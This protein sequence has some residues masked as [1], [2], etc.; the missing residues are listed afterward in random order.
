MKTLHTVF[1][2]LFLCF[3][4]S[5]L[6]QA[7]DLGNNQVSH[8][9]IE[10][11]EAELASAKHEVVRLEAEL[12]KAKQQLAGAGK[13]VTH[14]EIDVAP[15]AMTRITSEEL[16]NH[17]IHDATRVA[18]QVPGMLFGQ[19][20]NEAR[21]AI[22]GAHTNRTGPESEQV[23]AIYE[24]GVPALTTTQAL[25]PYVD[26]REIEIL[27]GPQGVMYG[28]NALGGVIA[29]HS[30]DPDPSG[31]DAALQG[32]IAFSDFTR[33]EAMLN[34]P[35]LET[36]AIRLA[37]ASESVSGYVNNYVLE[38]DA[39]DLKTRVRQFLRL[40]ARWQPSDDFSLQL[41][42]ASLDQNGTGSGMWGYQ[43]VG[44]M[45]DGSYYPGHHFAPAGA[46]PDHGP[47][48]IARNMASSAELE[49]LGTTLVL[50]W[51]LGFADLEWL[52]NTSKFESMQIFDGDYSNGGNP[53]NSDFNGW[54]SFM[55][56]VSSDLRLKSARQGRL[57]WLVGA[58]ALSSESDWSWLEARD[59]VQLKPGWDADGLYTTES[60]AV[61]ASAGFRVSDN[62]RVFGGLRWYE[63]QKQLRSGE[64]GSWDG[65]LW[66]AG[67][68]HGFSE[69]TIS[70]LRASTGYRP[71]GINPIAGVPA[72][73]DSEQVTAIELGF[74]SL[75]AHETLSLDAAAF[76]N[77]Y[78]DMQAQS[79]TILPLPGTAGLM[80]YLSTAGGKESKGLEIEMQWR[81][82]RHWDIA[83]QL[84]WLDAQFDHYTVAQPA[85]L[86]EIAGHSTADGLQLDGWQPAFSP[87]WSFGLQASYLFDVGRWGTFRPVLQ[88]SYTSDYYTNNFN[89]PGALQPAHQVTDVRL[90]WDLPGDKLRLQL[91]I[92]NFTDE[93]ILNA[94]SIYNPV[95]RPDIATF[96]AA[97]GDPRKYGLTLSYHY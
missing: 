8:E 59:S 57:D 1:P 44:A 47:W 49:N 93:E 3:F 2:Q 29:V 43:Q 12:S 56:T 91:Y 17:G 21:F 4:I 16:Q 39:D 28:R 36:L 96:L 40:S 38:S 11:L 25:G 79:F 18:Q 19:S 82:D 77:D 65:V 76:F 92:E 35:V 14:R 42:F 71:G 55:D 90:F 45:I 84:A 48:D 87:E 6:T 46:T 54:N 72:S 67:V 20:G 88:T 70:Y 33:F 95:E 23:L 78:S 41:K 60:T 80:D 34:M 58:H 9:Q 7:A 75:L 32:S 53:Y 69:R 51:N 37:G 86:G 83:A 85:G 22:R 66:N 5:G 73:Y 10:A 97:W 15:A 13:T 31:W 24:D 64:R 63:D 30:N 27:R 89:L 50:D 94:T 61:Y 74:K 26:V 52:A 81:P 62:T 68:E